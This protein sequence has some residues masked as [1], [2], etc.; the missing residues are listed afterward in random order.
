MPAMMGEPNEVPPAPDQ[1]LGE[2]VQ[3][4]PPFDVSDQQNM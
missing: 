3:A 2:P 4:A 1:L